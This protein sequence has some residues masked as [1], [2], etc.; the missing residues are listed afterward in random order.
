LRGLLQ[1]LAITDPKPRES[2]SGGEQPKRSQA[3][4]QAIF[5]KPAPRPRG[6]GTAAPTGRTF[7]KRYITVQ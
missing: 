5:G 2:T 3:Q 4:A 1:A 6:I 7:G